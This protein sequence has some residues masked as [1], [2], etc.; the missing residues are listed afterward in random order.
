MIRK[1][2]EKVYRY[3]EQL[4]MYDMTFDEAEE[5]C[6][7]L[8]ESNEKQTY[9]W[10]S[11]GGRVIVKYIDNDFKTHEELQEMNKK[12]LRMIKM[13]I[14]YPNHIRV[15]LND[16]HQVLAAVMTFMD[17]INDELNKLDGT[18]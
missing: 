6:K 14:T 11:A 8:T 18:P 3:G 1:C 4:G 2:N 16:G 9:D 10:F 17:R 12:L 7:R 15:D 5:M 13:C